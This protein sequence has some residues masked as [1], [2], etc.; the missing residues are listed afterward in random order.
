MFLI[1]LVG[2]N[3]VFPDVPPGS[4]PPALTLLRVLLDCDGDVAVSR[5]EGITRIPPRLP[6]PPPPPRAMRLILPSETSK[7]QTFSDL[8][9]RFSLAREGIPAVVAGKQAPS[10]F[11]FAAPSNWGPEVRL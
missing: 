2:Y 8:A 6:P 4:I 3:L 11:F 5:E 10:P 1:R 9:S 7:R